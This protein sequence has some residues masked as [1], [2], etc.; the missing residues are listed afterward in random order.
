MNNLELFGLVWLIWLHWFADFYMQSREVA[1]NK[2][3]DNWILTKHVLIYSLFFLPVSIKFA[4]INGV[5]H[6]I[7]DYFSSRE[8]TKYYKKQ[9]MHKFFLI[10]GADQAV[11]LT[12]IVILYNWLVI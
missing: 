7:T 3:S 11:H 10:I 2:S 6:W 8:T 1:T 9:D 4:I 12:C 5:L